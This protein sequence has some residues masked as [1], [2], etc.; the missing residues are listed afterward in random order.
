MSPF[1]AETV[2][3]S[4]RSTAAPQS[5][6]CRLFSSCSYSAQG[7]KQPAH[8]QDTLPSTMC[9]P[10]FQSQSLEFGTAADSNHFADRLR[11]AWSFTHRNLYNIHAHRETYP[12][13]RLNQFHSHSNFVFYLLSSSPSIICLTPMR[14]RLVI[15]EQLR[16]TALVIPGR[17]L[18]RH[19]FKK[20]FASND[21]CQSH[22]P[23]LL[24]SMTACLMFDTRVS[25]HAG[26]LARSSL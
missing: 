12:D 23:K 1:P 20:L 17:S 10:E 6:L 14:K 8:W 7:A 26:S 2:S 18:D 24:G 13:G 9:F 19:N 3:L 5:P 21:R 22:E 16:S 11:C 25:D 4:P 15:A